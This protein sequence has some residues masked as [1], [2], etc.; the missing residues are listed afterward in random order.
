M[1]RI[2]RIVQ[3]LVRLSILDFQ[4]LD[5]NTTLLVV[6][7]KLPVTRK[8]MTYSSIL[9]YAKLSLDICKSLTIRACMMLRTTHVL[10]GLLKN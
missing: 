8:F 7:E 4:G 5:D 3:P 2:G 6:E 9:D 1:L 10:G